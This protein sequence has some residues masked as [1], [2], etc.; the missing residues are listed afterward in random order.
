MVSAKSGT[1]FE[2]ET[3]RKRGMTLL[4]ILSAFRILEGL[5][6]RILDESNKQPDQAQRP[7][8]RVVTS[9]AFPVDG[10]GNGEPCQSAAPV[11]IPHRIEGAGNRLGELGA[12]RR[13]RRDPPHRTVGK[14]RERLD[15]ADR[16]PE[17]RRGGIFQHRQLA[18]AGQ[19]GQQPLAAE[20]DRRCRRLRTAR[21]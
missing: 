9:N 13:R 15:I 8:N 12:A 20:R 21:R 14:R 5:Q 3:R 1:S 10:V 2:R 16:S 18:I 19:F 4:E 17:R 11:E 6:K 7:S